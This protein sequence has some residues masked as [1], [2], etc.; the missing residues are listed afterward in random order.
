LLLSHARAVINGVPLDGWTL[1]GV[2]GSA[3]QHGITIRASVAGVVRL[4]V[5]RKWIRRRDRHGIVATGIAE[6]AIDT[7]VGV[8]IGHGAKPLAVD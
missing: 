5:V 3:G 4:G 1:P 7:A 6:G 2:S 8:E